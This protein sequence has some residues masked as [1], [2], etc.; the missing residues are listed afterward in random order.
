MIQIDGSQG[1]GGGQSP[2]TEFRET[3]QEGI[4]LEVKRG[5]FPIGVRPSLREPS[6][7]E[8]RVE[9]VGNGM[10]CVGVGKTDGGFGG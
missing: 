9:I 2:E 4:S 8:T 5:P 6:N 1:E 3:P 7:V 10:E